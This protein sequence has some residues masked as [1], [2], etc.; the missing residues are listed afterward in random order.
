MVHL[1]VIGKEVIVIEI[2]IEIEIE[3]GFQADTQMMNAMDQIDTQADKTD[4]Q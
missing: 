2:A 1:N 3:I 4:I